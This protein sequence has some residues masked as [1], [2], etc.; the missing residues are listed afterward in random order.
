[1]GGNEQQFASFKD[2]SDRFQN[3][4]E[5]LVDTCWSLSY[6]SDGLNDNIHAI[7]EPGVCEKLVQL[8]EHPSPLVVMPTSRSVGNDVTGDNI[9]N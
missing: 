2:I 6:L 3:D 5:I 7:L 1:M 4:V 8:L 9:Q